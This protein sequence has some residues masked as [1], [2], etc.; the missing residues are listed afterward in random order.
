M[1]D[2][3]KVQFY[4]LGFLLRLGP[5][6][7]Y[8]IKARIER[9]AAD[10]AHVKLPNLYYHLGRMGESG[11]VAA[12]LDREGNRP[13]KEV[14]SV[15]KE[16]KRAFAE[17]LD[18]CLDE[19]PV[20]DFAADGA[21]FF[22][23]AGSAPAYAEA[24]RLRKSRAEESLGRIAAHREEALAEVPEAFRDL[25]RLIFEHHELHMR[26]ELDWLDRLVAHFDPGKAQ[27][28]G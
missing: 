23:S 24:F 2:S 17:L 27:Q 7:G 12:R 6:H 9:E 19:S 26:A 5:L 22:A 1:T 13:E 10:F 28:G 20:W 14:Y 8:Q 21:L 11:W 15:T 4:I 3:Y 18:R 16:G 25:A